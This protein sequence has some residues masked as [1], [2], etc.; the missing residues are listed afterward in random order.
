[1]IPI[2]TAP[3]WSVHQ[4]PPCPR[5]P[6][7]ALRADVA[8]VGGGLAGLSAAYHLLERRPGTRVVLLEARRIGAGASG[9][10]T[11]LL[12]PGVGQSLTAL[13]RRHGPARARALYL[14]TLRAVEGVSGLVERE[15]IPCELEMTGHLVVARSWADRARLAADAALLRDLGLPGAPLDDNALEQAIRLPRVRASKPDGPA[16]LRLPAGGTLH[17]MRL[18][19]GLCERVVAR[20]GMIFEGARVTAFRGRRPVHLALEG[21]GEVVAND[22]VVATAGY[23]PDLGLLR[24]RILPVHL[25]VIVTAPLAPQAL[26]ALGWKGR[27]GIL[28]AR[29]IFNYFRLTGD[30]RVLFGGGRPRYAWGGSTEDGWRGEAALDR[31]AA[32]LEGTLGREIPLAVTGGWTGVIGYVLDALP[33]IERMRERPSMVCAVGWCGHGIALSVAS[34]EWVSRILYDGAAPD[35]LPWHRAQPPLLPLEPVRWAGFQATV[36]LMSLLDRIA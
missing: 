1:M 5:P 21:G 2:L 12:S 17:P 7:G 30:N 23:T 15:S 31:L 6:Q 9:R 36:R 20:G 29:R 24:G 22:V 35:D 16:A 18:L 3:L 34:G 11:G 4:P 28:D 8:V 10:T 14:A 26:D 32:E 19:S 27:E 33:A 25:Q 13:V